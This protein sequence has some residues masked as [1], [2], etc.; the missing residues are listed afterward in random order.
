MGLDLWVGICIATFVISGGIIVRIKGDYF[1]RGMGIALFTNIFGIIALVFS[2]PSRAQKSDEQDTHGW[3]PNAYLA[4]ITLM[5]L[6]FI[7][8]L[9]Y[10][11][12]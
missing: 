9:R 5:F 4:V 10:W 8:L 7:F 1:T 3:P 6:V 12:L 2:R 11:F